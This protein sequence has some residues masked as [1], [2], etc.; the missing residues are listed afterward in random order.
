[1]LRH[2]ETSAPDRFHGA[3]SDVGLGDAGRNHA[4]A[5]ADRIV[6]HRPVAVYSSGMKRARETADILSEACGQTTG[7]VP[8]LHERRMGPLSGMPRDRGFPIYEETLRRWVEGDLTFTHHEGAESY[9]TIRE[10]VVPPFQNMAHRHRGQTIVVV[11]H[12]VVIRVLLTSLVD[13]LTPQDFNRIGIGFLAVNDLRWN[14]EVWRA[15]N[16]DRTPGL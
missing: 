3:E 5:V 15:I 14:G 12:G 2:A 10:R 11:V 1:M 9:D 7:I 8:E 4:R 13:E 16:V 6:L